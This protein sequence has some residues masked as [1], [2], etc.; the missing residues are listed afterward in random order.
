MVDAH[1]K[2]IEA[3]HITNAASAVVTEVCRERFAQFGLPETLWQ[4]MAHVL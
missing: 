2:W 1:S 3:V 4:T